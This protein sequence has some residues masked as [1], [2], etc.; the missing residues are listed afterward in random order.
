MQQFP[1]MACIVSLPLYFALIRFLFSSLSL[2]TANPSW[3]NISDFGSWLSVF[4]FFCFLGLSKAKPL[5]WNILQGMPCVL[6]LKYG[7]R[8]PSP[9]VSIFRSNKVLPRSLRFV[10]QSKSLVFGSGLSGSHSLGLFKVKSTMWLAFYFL[11]YSLHLPRCQYLA[12]RLLFSSRSLSSSASK[13]SLTEYF[14]RVACISICEKN[15]H[16]IINEIRPNWK[17]NEGI[18]MSF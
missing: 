4:F 2:S 1:S 7:V 8:F 12:F 18:K 11:K 16:K 5:C 10:S 14:S 3:L 13:P 6:F 9:M 17:E 15:I